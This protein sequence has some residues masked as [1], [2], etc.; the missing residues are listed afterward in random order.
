MDWGP[1]ALFIAQQPSLLPPS[2]SP[3]CKSV[4]IIS[5]PLPP[6][7]PPL[8]S[9]SQM[10]KDRS[11]TLCGVLTLGLPFPPSPIPSSPPLVPPDLTANGQESLCC[12]RGEEGVGGLLYNAQPR[13][14]N[15]YTAMQLPFLLLPRFMRL[16]AS[17]RSLFFCCHYLMSPTGEG[18]GEGS[19]SNS[20]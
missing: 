1:G 11:E 18:E 5:P 12:G 16:I 3:G 15:V 10:H 13:Y 8:F 4:Q 9:L 2:K 17:V 20:S 14:N 7:L 19:R 6:I